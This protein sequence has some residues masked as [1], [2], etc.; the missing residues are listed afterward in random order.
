MQPAPFSNLMRSQLVYH[1]HRHYSLLCILNVVIYLQ[2]FPTTLLPSGILNDIIY[3]QAFSTTLSTFRHSQRHYLP[4]GIL[5]V[6]LFVHKVNQL[7][8]PTSP[9][10]PAIL[11]LGLSGPGRAYV[12]YAIP[13]N[14][15]LHSPATLRTQQYCFLSLPDL[16]EGVS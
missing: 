7:P 16:G 8:D 10:Y 14:Q 12:S 11:F 4:S 3:L 6:R 1:S 13:G 9:T 5:N 15:F 2:A